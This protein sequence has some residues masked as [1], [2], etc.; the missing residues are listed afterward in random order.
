MVLAASAAAASLGALGLAFLAE[1][2]EPWRRVSLNLAEPQ[3][4]SVFWV[5]LRLPT[6]LAEHLWS[7]KAPFL[8]RRGSLGRPDL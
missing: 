6:R 1:P 4:P 5:S 3:E 7:A 8:S 2:R